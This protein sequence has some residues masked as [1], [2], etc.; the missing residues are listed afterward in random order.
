MCTHNREPWPLHAGYGDV[1][2]CKRLQRNHGVHQ[3]AR[4]T[5]HVAQPPAQRGLLWSTPG[6]NGF[7][8]GHGSNIP[9]PT[10]IGSKMGWVD[11][12]PQ[13]GS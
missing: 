5:Q 3:Q 7:S 12:L 13:N 8:F 1:R 6:V 10:K 9:I 11:S 4:D 2:N